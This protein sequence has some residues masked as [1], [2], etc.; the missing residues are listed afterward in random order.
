MNEAVFFYERR[1]EFWD[2]W[3]DSVLYKIIELMLHSVNE[4]ASGI[5]NSGNM[6]NKGMRVIKSLLKNPII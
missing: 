5:D 3:L 2:I 4:Y 6:N 1:I